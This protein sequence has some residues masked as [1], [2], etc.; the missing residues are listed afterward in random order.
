MG[1][2]SAEDSTFMV[3]N[4][5]EWVGESGATARTSIGLGTVDSPSFTRLTLAEP[6][7]SPLVV[8]STAVN[9][10]FNADLLDGQHGTYYA[11]AGNYLKL[12]QTA[13]QDISGGQPDFLAGF[14]AGSTNQLSVD[15]SGNFH[16]T[17]T[18]RFDSGIGI[19]SAALSNTGINVGVAYSSASSIITGIFGA[20]TQT[21]GTI[22]VGNVQGL[23]FSANWTPTDV[24]GNRTMS[25][26]AGAKVGVTATSPASESNNMTITNV[27]GFSTY[28]STASLMSLKLGSGATSL[29]TATDVYHFRASD[30][31]LTG[32]GVTATT[33]TA[34]YAPAMTAG[35][36]NW[37]LGINVANN[38][39]NGSL[40]I[41]SAVAPTVALD[42]T[43]AGL[44]STTLGVTGILT[45][46]VAP[47]VNTL[48]AGRVIFAGASKELVDDG[49]LTFVT[50]TLISTHIQIGTAPTV[51]ST[52]AD[53]ILDRTITPAVNAGWLPIKDNTGTVRYVPYWA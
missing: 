25:I 20:A 38:Y 13:S 8:T 44:I 12:D 52:G 28:G 53:T 6:T 11:S 35:T 45:C 37:G 46:T 42:V 51:N 15:S 43:G 26:L 41:G 10:N 49:D 5:T 9:T 22:T 7:L 18:G 33:Q 31:V 3:G 47:I 27:E 24:V 34:F 48:T 50:D 36:T 16:T 17:G 4:G 30:I 2:I 32:A 19:G 23:N 14:R 21:K 29:I 1:K 40:R 39:V